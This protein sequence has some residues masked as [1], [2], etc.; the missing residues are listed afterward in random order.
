MTNDYY[1]LILSKD[2]IA[3]AP[4]LWDLPLLLLTFWDFC[5]VQ[6]HQTDHCLAIVRFLFSISF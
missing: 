5:E 1:F 4:L 2:M 6:L 3:Y